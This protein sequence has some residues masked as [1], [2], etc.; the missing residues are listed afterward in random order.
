MRNVVFE[1]KTIFIEMPMVKERGFFDIKGQ[2]NLNKTL[3]QLDSYDYK[4][5][6]LGQRI[7]IITSDRPISGTPAVKFLFNGHNLRCRWE[8]EGKKAYVVIEESV[9]N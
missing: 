3:V 7:L 6:P 1:P 9:K 4:D 8:V 2:V 5:V